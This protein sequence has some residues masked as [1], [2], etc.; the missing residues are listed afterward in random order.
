MCGYQK[1]DPFIQI[2]ISVNAFDDPAIKKKITANITLNQIITEYCSEIFYN[3]TSMILQFKDL[4]NYSD[5]KR[6]PFK[7]K[8]SKKNLRDIERKV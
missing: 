2:D 7:S 5:L 1:E 8:K 4:F 3:M 6:A